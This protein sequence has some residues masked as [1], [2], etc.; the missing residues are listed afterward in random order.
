MLPRPSPVGSIRCVNHFIHTKE[1]GTEGNFS[2]GIEMN[3]K[4]N[5]IYTSRY[6]DSI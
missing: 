5:I 2:S 3:Y 1:E 4:E 6:F